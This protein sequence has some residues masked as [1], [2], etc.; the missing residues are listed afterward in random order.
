MENETQTTVSITPVID[1][2]NVSEPII[3]TCSQCN[4]GYRDIHSMQ[5]VVDNEILCSDCFYDRY[6]YCENCNQV[7]HESDVYHHD[8]YPYC[9]SCY[10]EHYFYCNECDTSYSLDEQ[11]NDDNV[12]INCYN[13]DDNEGYENGNYSQYLKP[14]SKDNYL[15]EKDHRAFS[16]E[17]E[18]Y[19]K[20]IDGL[21]K[22]ANNISKHI[23]ITTDG[24]LS[25]KGLEF[26]TP[27]LSGKKGRK[28]LRKLTN[29]LKNNGFTVDKTCG[30]H[31][32]LDT[33]DIKDN[34]EKI[35][36]IFLFYIAFEPV[37][38]SYLPISR[39]KNRY[40]LPLT[41]FY[42]EN[43]IKKC[44]NL[45]CIEQMWYREQ[46][47]SSIEGRKKQ[48]YDSSRYS[49]INLHSLLSNGHI[50]IRYHS[51][52]L[53]YNKI[54]KWIE[55]HVA[56]L[57]YISKTDSYIVSNALRDIKYLV[58][59][60]E[61]QEKMFNILNLPK[62]LQNYFKDRQNKFIAKPKTI[63]KEIEETNIN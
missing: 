54:I 51:G 52:T 30:L 26:I 20:T 22:V 41:E 15:V 6:N 32:H 57:D 50:E 11:S 21:K 3:F 43:E 55:L 60:K 62:N 59:L 17:I 49:G 46:S 10:N 24:S 63:I 18:C 39:R 40:C 2:V 27:K 36:N 28:A 25:S 23:G 48:R 29:E 34:Y 9:Q 42:H 19:Y 61:K 45:T 53:I 8:D 31:I 58:S 1:T 13:N 35:K 44:N 37:I 7:V 47:L 4:E 56:I 12:C 14:Y 5:H 16:C 38:F 33:E